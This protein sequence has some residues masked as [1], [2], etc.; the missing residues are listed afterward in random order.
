[1]SGKNVVLIVVV[2]VL[3]VAAGGAAYYFLAPDNA[4]LSGDAADTVER[5]DADAAEGTLF[6]IDP[7]RS[8]AE[9]HIDE[10]LRGNDVTVVG[11]TKQIAGDIIINVANPAASTIGEIRINARDLTTPESGRNR[12][13]RQFILLSEQDQYEFITFSPTAI[14]NMPESVTVGEAFSFQVVGDLTVKGETKEVTFDV[15]VTANS[16]TEIEGT[17]ETT[18]AYKDFGI[19]IP[20][21]PF[22]ASVEDNVL[23]KLDFVAAE[24]A[25]ETEAS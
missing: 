22:V 25:A 17:A 1:M 15:T 11:V 12:A 21:V 20:D 3:L 23:L 16:E 14:N 8:Q 19:N 5:L 2:L 7:E 6:T 24:G 18:V 9:F 10:V 13:L 4:Q